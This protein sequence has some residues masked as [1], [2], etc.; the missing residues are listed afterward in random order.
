M[1]ETI[2]LLH[3]AS[4]CRIQPEA[5]LGDR[6]DAFRQAIAGAIYD[7][8]RRVNVAT[9]DKVHPILVRLREAGFTTTMDP[10]L[11]R[12][13]QRWTAEQWTDLKSAQER[14]ARIDEEIFA[15]KG[16]RLFP[17]QK[18]GAQWLALRYGALLADEQGTGK[19]LQAIV[20]LPAN[21]PV[22]VCG[23]SAAKSVW[24]GETRAWRPH[25]RATMLAGRGSFRWPAQGEMLVTNYAILPQ[26]HD[27]K[28]EA[29]R[30]CEGFLPPK[31]CTGCKE[32]ILFDGEGVATKRKTGHLKTCSGFLPPENCPGCHPM[33]RDVLPGTV[34]VWDEAHALK[35]GSSQRARQAQALSDAARAKNGRVWV[36]TGTPM[37]NEPKD[38]WYVLKIA[39]IHTEAFGSWKA[40][41]E[42]FKGKAVDY[43]Y[44]WGVPDEEVAERIKRVAMRRLKSEVLPDMPEKM[45]QEAIVEIDK[46]TLRACDALLDDLGGVEKLEAIVNQSIKFETMS[47][48][49]AALAT[50][51]I[52]ALLELVEELEKAQEPF[53][54]FSMHREPIDY[55]G[56]R[57]GWATITGD[58]STDKRQK[59][60][61][62]F[63]AGDLLGLACT[64]Q[65]SGTAITLTR[66]NRAVFVDLSFKPSEN[67][68]AEDRIH[69]I[70][71]KRGVIYTI[72]KANHP[73]DARV[74]EI[75]MT[76]REIIAA[77]VDAASVTEDAPIQEGSF[78]EQIKKIQ[79]EIAEGRA[80]R[81]M[82]ES[83][84][85]KASLEKLHTLTFT[86]KSDERL[87]L[88]LAEEGN[89]IGLS[90]AQWALAARV[91]E[92]GHDVAAL[93]VAIKERVSCAERAEDQVIQVAARGRGKKS[94]MATEK[95]A[96]TNASVAVVE[97]E[98][99]SRIDR[100]LLLIKAMD[101]EE[102]EDLFDAIGSHYCTS[103]AEPV[104]RNQEHAC[105]YDEDD[106][107]EDD[108]EDDE[109]DEDDDLD[110]EDDEEEG[111]VTD[112]E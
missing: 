4:A 70:G 101:V 97:N 3:D 66:A 58:D 38:L 61:E 104:K 40:F 80:V 87:A 82:A 57:E 81:R 8:K 75:L 6:F 107:D 35:N 50:A 71:Q 69:R 67:E 12:S 103:C 59:T 106:D 26:I 43:G 27:T 31:R 34:L 55:L 5:W 72:L 54:V 105:V 77:S 90:E 20:S 13:L 11:R 51:K 53:V 7:R 88:K 14:I 21:A 111:E 46:K 41:V 112:K 30:A 110:D 93:A 16:K 60:I 36:M 65:S 18:T 37:E 68:Q 49:R 84:G 102:R 42:L 62:K 56:E 19:T 74:T 109:D 10:E 9:I 15:H 2:H 48:I 108:D 24:I 25:L 64:I 89:V 22:L 33:L 29:G 95:K 98:G 96:K 100:V 86:S 99:D 78:E 76:K 45:W 28:G 1:H 32:E 79:I 91:V 52:P 83:D 73:L 23:P 94:T 44:T 92:R 17:Y 85:E 47:R 63:Q 39:G